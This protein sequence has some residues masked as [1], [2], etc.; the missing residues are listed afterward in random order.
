MAAF[1]EQGWNYSEKGW[2]FE[3]Y[4]S[5]RFTVPDEKGNVILDICAYLI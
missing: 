5:P 1:T 2:F 4:N 3:R